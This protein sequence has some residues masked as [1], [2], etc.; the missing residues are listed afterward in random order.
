MGTWSTWLKQQKI[1]RSTADRLVL[2]YAETHGLSDD[3]PHREGEPQ[4]GNIWCGRITY[5]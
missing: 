3:F 5:R 4:E 2:E 1:S